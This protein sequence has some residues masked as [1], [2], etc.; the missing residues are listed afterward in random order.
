MGNRLFVGNLSFSVQDDDLQ[1]RF[2]E[3]GTVLSVKVMFD[4]DT[5]RSKGFAFV[6][7]SSP[8]EAQAAIDALSGKSVDGRPLTV[9]EARPREERPTGSGGQRA[10]GGPRGY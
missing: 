3:F 1:Q 5:G 8:A 9:N 4:R 7:M 6:E 10:Y 2:A